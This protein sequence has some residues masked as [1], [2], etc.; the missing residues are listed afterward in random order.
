VLLY[1][2]KYGFTTGPTDVKKTRG[3][4]GTT[5]AVF[6]AIVT[7]L[8]ASALVSVPTESNALS[9][10]INSADISMQTNQILQV[11]VPISSNITVLSISGEGYSVQSMKETSSNVLTFTP[12]NATLF[13]L[14]L[15]VTSRSSSNFAYVTKQ[16]SP[17]FVQACSNCNFTGSGNL[18][19][20]LNV[21]ATSS[22]IQSGSVWDPLTGMLPLKVQN[23]ALNF[24]DVMVILAGF[25]F[26]ILALGIGFRSKVVYL[27]L[28]ILF[29]LGLIEFGLIV[30]FSLIGGY[31][32][33]FALINI[34]WKHRSW[35]SRK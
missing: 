19:V 22:S 29:I 26:A 5:A 8:L 12:N 21:N 18:L 23:F 34:F 27:G 20:S 6:V 33:S 9:R 13:T 1:S 15:N 4:I 35:R 28:A 16:S 24:L 31:F 10:G 11:S 14:V 2:L 3:N 30:M 17:V 7:F 25:G 32:V